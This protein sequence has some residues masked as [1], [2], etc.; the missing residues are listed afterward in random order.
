[1]SILIFEDYQ[2]SFPFLVTSDSLILTVNQLVLMKVSQYP[3]VTKASAN[4]HSL[5]GR[6]K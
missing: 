3:G 4:F 2:F 6:S 5:S 1:M